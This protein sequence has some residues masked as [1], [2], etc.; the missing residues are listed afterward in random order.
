VA[1]VVLSRDGADR[2]FV[3]TVCT[4]SAASVRSLHRVRICCTLPC[5]HARCT[6]IPKF[7]PLTAMAICAPSSEALCF[8]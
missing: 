4:V 3:P 2:K 8:L 7:Y 1:L 5:P 6:T